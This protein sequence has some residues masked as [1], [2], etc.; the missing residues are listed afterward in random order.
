MNI[1]NIYKESRL[2]RLVGWLLVITL[3]FILI[4]GYQTTLTRFIALHLDVLRNH[5]ADFP[6][7]F[8]LGYLLTYICLAGCFVP[9]TLTMALLAGAVF[10]IPAGLIFLSVAYTSA[11]T[12]NFMLSRF[13]LYKKIHKEYASE[14][15]WIDA[16]IKKYGWLYLIFLRLVPLLPGQVINLVVGAL[17]FRLSIF[18]PITWIFS[19]PLLT[20][21]II[22]S[23]HLA[24]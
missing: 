1:K 8:S 20:I 21:Y 10:G 2:K 23:M 16:G 15:Q 3:L 19:L 18:I 11:A 24:P 17:P 6:R 7:L 14:L 9:I 4:G 13:F 12:I 22:I 5:Y